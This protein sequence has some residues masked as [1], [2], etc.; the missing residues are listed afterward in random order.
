MQR[1]ADETVKCPKCGSSKPTVSS[2]RRGPAN[3]PPRRICGGS[4]GPR[5]A[6]GAESASWWSS[7]TAS[8]SWRRAG[9]N[10]SRTWYSREPQT[11]LFGRL[12]PN[13][14]SNVRDRGSLCGWSQRVVTASTTADDPT[15][16][17]LKEAV[18]CALVLRSRHRLLAHDSRQVSF[19][20]PSPRRPRRRC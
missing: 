8:F 14:A 13:L 4:A 1:M 12:P 7:H 18:M 11:T 9:R 10:K 6:C 16:I 5:Y 15:Y 2:R 17:L 20:F 3:E 19:A